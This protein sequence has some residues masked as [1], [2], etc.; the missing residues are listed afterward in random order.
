MAWPAAGL[1]NM[2]LRSGAVLAPPQ[3][4]ATVGELPVAEGEPAWQFK[5]NLSVRVKQIYLSLLCSIL[6][7][8]VSGAAEEA[9][10]QGMASVAT[11]RFQ[12]H[13]C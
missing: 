9:A 4:V 11:Q 13:T 7:P 3:T 2:G 6:I 5:T 8:M 12:W 1:G 10:S